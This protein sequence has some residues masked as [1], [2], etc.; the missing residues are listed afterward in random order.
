MLRQKL[1]SRC[2]HGTVEA[3]K[4]DGQSDIGELCRMLSHGRCSVVAGEFHG[5]IWQRQLGHAVWLDHSAK[6]HSASAL[7]D[8]NVLYHNPTE[9]RAA[10]ANTGR[11]VRAKAREESLLVD[12]A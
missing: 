4:Q 3:V 6:D 12:M 8:W 11:D 5:E 2:A 1:L 10:P 7:G 9:T